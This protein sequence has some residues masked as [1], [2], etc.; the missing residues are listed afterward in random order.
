MLLLHRFWLTEICTCL[1]PRPTRDEMRDLQI[2]LP[3][4]FMLLFFYTASP[5]HARH[6][7][8][9]FELWGRPFCSSLLVSFFRCCYERNSI[10]TA[11]LSHFISLVHSAHHFFFF[12]FPAA[13]SCWIHVNVSCST[14]I[15][16]ML[17]ILSLNDEPWLAHRRQQ[18]VGSAFSFHNTFLSTHFCIYPFELLHWF[19]WSWTTIRG[20]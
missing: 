13:D 10:H 7:Y 17:L 6:I 18:S 3:M 9:I 1:K 15:Y 16:S 2:A 12:F 11:S 8:T 4:T 19:L 14:C 20:V 5:L